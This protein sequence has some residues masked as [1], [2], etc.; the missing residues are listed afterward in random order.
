MN[1]TVPVICSGSFPSKAVQITIYSL[2]MASSLIGNFLVVGVFYRNKTLRAAVHYFIMNMAI[3]DLIYP[4]VYLPYRLSTSYFGNVWLIQGFAGDVLC[5]LT[6]NAGNLSNGVSTFS[7]IVISVDRFHGVVFPMKPPLL[8]RT[9]CRFVIV[10]V[11]LAAI[12]FCSPFFYL[13][14]LVPDD[15]KLLRC[16]FN[17]WLFEMTWQKLILIFAF[18]VTFVSALVLT[19]L[20]SSVVVRLYRQKYQFNLATEQIRR[21][22][23]NN[24]R[25]TW[26]LLTVIILFYL[27]W[28]QAFSVNF[29]FLKDNV[30]LPCIYTWSSKGAILPLYTAVNPVV[31]YIY[32]DKYRQG[33]KDLL[34]FC[35]PSR[36]V[37]VHNR[38]RANNASH[39]NDAI[40]L[41]QQ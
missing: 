37:T 35:Y 24:R 19:V 36:A 23:K 7:M 40:E 39:T 15:N 9:K 32:N 18:S 38:R 20:Y 16:V 4:V 29:I 1:E 10:C 8:S 13:V 6:W 17:R 12:A 11:W 3:S 14:K 33:F 22:N 34:C 28:I 31:Y 21:R 25:I 2:L 27:I 30:M 26:M 41:E 5:K